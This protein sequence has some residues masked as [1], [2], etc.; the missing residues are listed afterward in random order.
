MKRAQRQKIRTLNDD[1]VEENWIEISCNSQINPLKQM[2]DMKIDENENKQN[3][4]NMEKKALLISINNQTSNIQKRS[5]SIR[6][7]LDEMQLFYWAHPILTPSKEQQ[8]ISFNRESQSSKVVL[9]GEN[10]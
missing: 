7:Y 4:L 8:I 5:F 3:N 2:N 1:V 10:F 6:I 9:L